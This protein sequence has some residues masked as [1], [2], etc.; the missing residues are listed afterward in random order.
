MR[1][2]TDAGCCFRQDQGRGWTSGLLSPPRRPHSIAALP[3]FPVSRKRPHA[4]HCSVT[5]GRDRRKERY[6]AWCSP[7]NLPLGNPYAGPLNVAASAQ[8]SQTVLLVED[9]DSLREMTEILLSV[10]GYRVIACSD[11]Q[12][13]SQAFLSDSAGKIDLLL[14]DIE[15]PGR[16]GIDLAR[17]LTVLRPSLPVLI[18]SG[19]LLSSDLEREMGDRSW[20]FVGKPF[21]LP[22]L[23]DAVER[24]LPSCQ[25]QV[26]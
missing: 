19:S 15:M 3:S 10:V 26:S 6:R 16:S 20:Q 21:L 8:T 12:I 23:M 25:Q 11:A 7:V 2:H 1:S 22:T 4:F 14:T 17:E 5:T 13:A 9:D 24:L 18:V